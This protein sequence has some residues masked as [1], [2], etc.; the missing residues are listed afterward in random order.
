MN[1]H[2]ALMIDGLLAREL[3]DEGASTYLDALSDLVASYEDEHHPIAPPS[4]I[5]LSSFKIGFGNSKVGNLSFLVPTIITRS[6]I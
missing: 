2:E 4:E 1:D 5:Q 6:L 3:S